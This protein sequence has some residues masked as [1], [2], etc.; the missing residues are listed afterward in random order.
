MFTSEKI[1]SFSE[2][3][4]MLYNYII[5]HAHKIVYMR[6]RDLAKETHVSTTTILRFCRKLGCDGFSEFKVKLKLHLEEKEKHQLASTK[7]VA[8]EFLTRTLSQDYDESID[9]IS[10]LIADAKHVIFIGVG[11]SGIL[12]EYGARFFSNLKKFSLHIKDPFFPIHGQVLK[13][14]VTIVLS[15]SGETPTTLSQVHQFKEEGSVIISI[16]N[17]THC[18]LSSI[19]DYNL[20][21]YVTPE[22]MGDANITTQIPVVFLLET[23]AKATYAQLQ[24]EKPSQS[25]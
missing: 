17:Q 8:K 6:V 15:V 9:K 10:A 1:A 7:H 3:E 19:S 13:D 25:E 2:L 22:Y 12:A 14:S 16:T 24:K 4:F 21:Y 20:S 18:T 5:L 23:L 11:S